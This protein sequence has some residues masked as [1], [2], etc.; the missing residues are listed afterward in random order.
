M[1]SIDPSAY[2]GALMDQG[3]N[4]PASARQAP[5]AGAALD[6]AILTL[7]AA[8][9]PGSQSQ[10]SPAQQ[11]ARK[12]FEA[13]QKDQQYLDVGPW[14]TPVPIPHWLNNTFLGMGGRAAQ[15]GQWAKQSFGGDA[16]DEMDAATQAQAQSSTA[17]KVGSFITDAALTA[18]L[19]GAVTSGVARLGGIG[20]RVAANTFGRAAVQG[21]V[22]G[23]A[24]A[25]PGSRLEGAALGTVLSPVLPFLGSTAGKVVRGLTRTPEAQALLDRGAQLTPGQM[26]PG[27]PVVNRLEQAFTSLPLVGGMIANARNRAPQQF[28][29]SFLEDATA[30]GQTLTTART[31]FNGLVADAQ[32]GFDRAYDQTLRAGAPGGRFAVQPGIAQGGA[33]GYSV[34]QPLSDVF[35]QIADTPRL[36]LT[37]SQRQAMGE[38]LQEK[39][40]ETLAVSKQA[41]GM[42]ADDLQNLRSDLRAAGRDV[43]PVDNASR[44]QKGFWNDAQQAVTQ[45]LESQLPTDTTQALRNIDSQYAKFAIARRAAVLA[46]DQPGGPTPAQFGQ[47]VKEATSP[48]AYAAGGGFNRDA[49]KAAR[50]VFQSTVPQTGLTGA[51]MV[52]PV[53]HAAEGVGG[54]L[55]SL[56]HPVAAAGA[57][58]AIGALAGAYSRPG[59]RALAGQ[60]GLQQY[61]KGRLGAVPPAIQE[62]LSRYGRTAL[63]QPVLS[64]ALQPQAQ[65]LAP[66]MAPA[67]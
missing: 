58:G 6:K 18:P 19:G 3:S 30:P 39:L 46:K 43:S 26:N 48:S 35:Q 23:A 10:E 17:G 7:A 22:Q 28:A 5:P 53:V 37:A 62:A 40:A 51:G 59:L 49:V 9:A 56:H 29:R 45:S 2:L 31:D 33:P 25:P 11:A 50:G 34:T 63:S 47:A 64:N 13:A 55:L 38:Q 41:G 60:T 54:A 21:A 67:Q 42:T 27:G 15:L 57:A 12:T 52:L 44:A 4:T 36:G 24:T 65:S 61:L 8:T 16:P 14:Q 20:A 1:D 66:W 32:A